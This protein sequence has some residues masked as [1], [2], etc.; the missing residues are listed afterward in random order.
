MIT[1]GDTVRDVITGFTGIAVARSEWLYGC[2]R[3]GVESKKLD[4]D[5]KVMEAQWFDEQRLELCGESKPKVIKESL[6]R[7]G[8]P[9][10]DPVR[11]D[12]K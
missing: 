2:V 9:R 1:L 4:K 12:A 5:G 10:K 6:A 11:V 3:L 8:G 7:T